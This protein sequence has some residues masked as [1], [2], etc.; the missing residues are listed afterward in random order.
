MVSEGKIFSK[1][2]KEKEKKYHSILRCM[3]IFLRNKTRSPF[4]DLSM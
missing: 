4:Y 1:K 3:K 2:I